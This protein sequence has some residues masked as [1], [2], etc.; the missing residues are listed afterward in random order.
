MGAVSYE[1]G[2]PVN[3]VERERQ[4]LLEKAVIQQDLGCSIKPPLDSHTV[5]LRAG[6]S[7]AGWS[8]GQSRLL[9]GVR[10]HVHSQVPGVGE[11]LAVQG[12]LAHKKHPPPRT[13]Q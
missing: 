4:I 3:E 6:I 9:P 2:T 13:L 12:Y 10:P 5:R 1:R 11:R 7:E 8:N